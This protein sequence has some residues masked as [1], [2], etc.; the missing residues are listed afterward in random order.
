MP[1]ETLAGDAARSTQNDTQDSIT[2]KVEGK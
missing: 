1:N 2:I